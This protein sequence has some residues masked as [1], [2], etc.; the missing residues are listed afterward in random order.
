[1]YQRDKERESLEVT[2]SSEILSS[3]LVGQ[4]KYIGKEKDP[5]ESK[6]LLIGILKSGRR[7][8]LNQPCTSSKFSN[9]KGASSIIFPICPKYSYVANSTLQ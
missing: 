9:I 8:T 2:L 1:M 4:G 7:G 5:Q 3:L 6:E